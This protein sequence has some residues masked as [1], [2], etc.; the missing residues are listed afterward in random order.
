MKV[1][2]HALRFFILRPAKFDL[3][4]SFLQI[5]KHCLAQV[6]LTLLSSLGLLHDRDL[7]RRQAVQ[8][9]HQLI[10]LALQR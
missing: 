3:G 10:N 6:E 1:L 2:L 7:L 9:V 8:P 5:L 4:S